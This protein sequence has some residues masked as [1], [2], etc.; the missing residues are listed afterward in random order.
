M[1][2]AAGRRRNLFFA[3]Y[4]SFADSFCHDVVYCVDPVHSEHTAVYR[5]YR[6]HNAYTAVYRP[7]REHNAYTAVYRPYRNHVDTALNNPYATGHHAYS[8]RNITLSKSR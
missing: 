5:P 2:T 6:E 8:A 7:Y 4:Y 1:Y 3:D